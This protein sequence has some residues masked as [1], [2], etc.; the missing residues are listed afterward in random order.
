MSSR[1]ASTYAKRAWYG[2]LL[3]WIFWTFHHSQEEW[4]GGRLLANNELARFAA[5][6]FEWLAVGQAVI[7]MALLPAMVAGSV[8]EERTR[9]T[10]PTLLATRFSS[11]G[12]ILNKLGR[13]CSRSACSSP[14]GC[15]SPVC[16]VCLAASI[17]CRSPMR[18]AERP[19]QPF[20]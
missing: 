15:R 3:L 18:T 4:S 1:Q 2:L 19:Q 17:L 14:S 16:S 6:A 20:S 12:I 9:H 10:L 7:V 8:A 5:A 11:A 13:R